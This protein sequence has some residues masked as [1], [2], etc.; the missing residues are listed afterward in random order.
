MKLYFLSPLALGLAAVIL[1]LTPEM[2]LAQNL[3]TPNHRVVLRRNC[4]E[5]NVTCNNVSYYG[6]NF[7]TGASIRLKGRTV[8]APC[9]D[10]V[11][12]CRFLGYEFLN[13]DTR[14]F[15]REDGELTVTQGRRLLLREMGTWVPNNR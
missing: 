10:Q 6:I 5:G 15:V 4:P 2:L 11:T 13:G 3:R 12:P 7:R 9:R 14:Y 1:A 8:H